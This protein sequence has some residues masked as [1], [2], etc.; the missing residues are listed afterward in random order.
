MADTCISGLRVGC[1][2]T[3]L[4]QPRRLPQTI[5]SQNRTELSSTAIR[6]WAGATR[7]GWHYIARARRSRTAPTKAS[8]LERSPRDE[9][10][11]EELFRLLG[12]AG[13]HGAGALAARL[14]QAAS[15][16]RSR[17]AGAIAHRAK[18]SRAIS[19]DLQRWLKMCKQ[20]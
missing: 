10:P 13:P 4:V 15:T 16:L 6:T 17:M 20:I 7:L 9:L 18:T 3:H 19:D 11:R 5:L 1:D 14:Q 8:T 2:L 12:Q